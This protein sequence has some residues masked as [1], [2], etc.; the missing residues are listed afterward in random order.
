MYRRDPDPVGWVLEAILPE[1]PSACV[2]ARSAVIKGNRA[3]VGASR[4]FE[5]E[6]WAGAVYI[7]R[8]DGGSW[9]L[10]QKLTALDAGESLDGGQ[11]FADAISVSGDRLGVGATLYGPSGSAYVFRRDGI[12]WTNEGGRLGASDGDSAIT[13]SFGQSV[14]LEGDTLVVGAHSHSHP[15]LPAD[16]GSAYVF[17]RNDAGTPTNSDDDFWEEV[18]ELLQGDPGALDDDSFGTTVAISG[19]LVVIGAP[20][21]EDPCSQDQGCST[22][23]F[24]VCSL[25]GTQCNDTPFICPDCNANGVPDT[26]DIA[27]CPGDPACDDCNA[28]GIPDECDIADC[29]PGDPSCQDADGNGVPDECEV[30]DCNQNGIPDEEEGTQTLAFVVQCPNPPAPCADGTRWSFLLIDP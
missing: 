17:Q 15:G 24:Y 14:A 26:C 13:E 1:Q 21:D 10:E 3:Y 18:S 16:S 22:G 8:R 5:A 7:F 30:V 2:F 23:S 25:S 9:T 27:N 28:N 6:F 29:P 20:G 19:D 11:R 12:T 4:D